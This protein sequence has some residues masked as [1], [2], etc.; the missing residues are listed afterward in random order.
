MGPFRYIAE[1]CTRR[2]FDTERCQL[3]SAVRDELIEPLAQK[4]TFGRRRF[5]YAGR[6]LWNALQTRHIRDL[7]LSLCRF[8]TKLKSFLHREIYHLRLHTCLRDGFVIRR[9]YINFGTN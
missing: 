1:I 5:L 6:S 3:R 7:S 9:R 4:V 8:Q 2:S